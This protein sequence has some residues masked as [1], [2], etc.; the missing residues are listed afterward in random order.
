MDDVQ[1]QE[2]N[3]IFLNRGY[4][5]NLAYNLLHMYGYLRRRFQE[6]MYKVQYLIIKRQWTVPHILF[7][8][9]LLC[10]LLLA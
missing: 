9:V 5:R 10:F 7:Q 3:I 2:E 8:S 6:L 1:K 4:L